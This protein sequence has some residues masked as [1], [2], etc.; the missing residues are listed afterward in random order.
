MF[1]FIQKYL[2]L[3]LLSLIIFVPMASAQ[4]E[5][6]DVSVFKAKV[7]EITEQKE[8]KAPDGTVFIQQKL[9]L[10]GL[11]KQW[12]NK[13]IIYDDTNYDVLSASKYR[14][15]DRVIVNYSPNEGGEDH[16]YIVDYVR[17]NAIYWL[18]LIFVLG[19]I[20]VGRW[21]GLRALIVLLLTFL[22]ILKFIVPQIMSGTSPLLVVIIGSLII[23][24]LSIYITE[25][26]N[27]ESHIAITSI[28]VSLVVAGVLSLIFTELAKLNGFANEDVLF[29]VGMTGSSINIKGLFLAGVII[30]ALGVLDDV[31]IAQISVVAELKQSLNL[32]NLEVYRRAM[33]VGVSHLSSM[34]NTLFLAYAGVALPL[35]ILFT[36]RS[37][38][39]AAQGQII[40]NESIATEIIRTLVGSI[41]LIF[42]VPVSTFLAAKFVKRKK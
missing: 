24:F 36:L 12:K 11:E 22:I 8:D 31:V 39:I 25:G 4:E 34:V 3:L 20:I 41:G 17:Q 5:I 15:G 30:G 16:Y 7:I 19:V 28:F 1:K 2:L 42:A 10:I 13:E 14:V 6:N 18:A 26:Y 23:L 40:N 9:K 35:F 38:E 33:K 37:S 27:R 32:S 29:L 21:K